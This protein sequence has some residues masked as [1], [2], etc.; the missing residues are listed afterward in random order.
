MQDGCTCIYWHC[1]T[2]C[3]VLSKL[4]CKLKWNEIGMTII[5]I[6]LH[7]HF[8]ECLGLRDLQK[9]LDDSLV[10][11]AKIN[12]VVA[13]YVLNFKYVGGHN[14]PQ[15]LER[16]LN[17]LGWTKVADL[18]TCYAKGIASGEDS[19]LYQTDIEKFLKNM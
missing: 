16:K 12:P 9:A 4:V 19:N 3:N 18:T 7:E 1:V 14:N 8:Q 15:G 6:K 2:L 13:V 5:A 10:D 17:H 11:E